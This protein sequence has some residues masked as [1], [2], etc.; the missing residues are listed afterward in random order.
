M[1]PL[2]QRIL[3]AR[4][5]HQAS[6]AGAAPAFTWPIQRTK[7]LK[8]PVFIH[9]HPFPS[10]FCQSQSIQRLKMPAKEDK[11]NHSGA[12]FEA[13]SSL[14]A[15]VARLAIVR[16]R[17]HKPAVMH[18]LTSLAQRIPCRSWTLQAL[19]VIRPSKNRRN[20]PKSLYK[21]S[22]FVDCFI[23]RPW[24]YTERL[25][26][27]RGA[28]ASLRPEPACGPSTT[29]PRPKGPIDGVHEPS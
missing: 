3:L 26:R 21:S 17:L 1:L 11:H 23:N 2:C 28:V 4:Q 13:R 19:S 5:H 20:H 7:M 14:T 22:R 6:L 27:L 24:T 16:H 25:F 10:V 18:Q 9:Y 29:R 8:L 15:S 12:T